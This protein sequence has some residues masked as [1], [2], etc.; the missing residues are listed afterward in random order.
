MK[1]SNIKNLAPK[2]KVLLHS[3][4]F[5]REFRGRPIAF[6]RPSQSAPNW[7]YQVH[8]PLTMKN[9]ISTSQSKTTIRISLF[10][11]M[12]RRSWI[13]RI[14]LPHQSIILRMVMMPVIIDRYLCMLICEWT[15]QTSWFTQRSF[16]N[17]TAIFWNL[18]SL[19][20]VS[21]RRIVFLLMICP[22][23]YDDESFTGP[24]HTAALPH[25]IQEQQPPT[26]EHNRDKTRVCPRAGLRVTWMHDVVA[27]NTPSL[28]GAIARWQYYYYPPLFEYS[29]NS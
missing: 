5:P 23:F 25:P 28:T 11:K 17:G 24:C 10:R 12:T 9:I 15:G 1:I 8:S 7:Y 2:S 4:K 26:G 14:S 13:S 3:P 29:C 21:I 22:K 27:N 18:E 19:L 6:F 20:F 16:C